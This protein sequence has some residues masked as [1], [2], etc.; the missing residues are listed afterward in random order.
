MVV[1]GGDQGDGPAAAADPADDGAEH[2]GELGADDQEPFGV[3]LGRGD[4]QERDELAGG[5]QPVLDQAVVA[6]L[7]QF[8]DPDAG[9]AEHLDDR[10]GPEGVVFFAGQVAA[11]P[12]GGVIG[13]DACPCR[14]RGRR[15]GR[16]SGP[17]R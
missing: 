4:L 2:V 6:E 12:G 7:E 17:R 10:P 15:S 9:G 8:L 11:F 3:G 14:E 1:V 5:G 13:P 16:G